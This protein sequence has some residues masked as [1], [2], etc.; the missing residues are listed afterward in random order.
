VIPGLAATMSLDAAFLAVAAV[1][2]FAAVACLRLPTVRVDVA[3]E[4]AAVQP[5]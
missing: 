4:P 5:G 1:V 3:P 2:L